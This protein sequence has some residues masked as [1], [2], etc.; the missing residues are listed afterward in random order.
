LL[1]TLTGKTITLDVEASDTIENMKAKIQ[2]KIG[3]SI[4]Q[5][6]PTYTG[7]Q[8]EH[9]KTLFDYDIQKE[10]LLHLVPRLRGGMPGHS[11][12]IPQD[13]WQHSDIAVTFTQEQI[14]RN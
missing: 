13:W 1:K 5:K 8:L 6:C 12:D 11:A 7:K 14:S 2:D 4:D 9:G 10:C 3:I